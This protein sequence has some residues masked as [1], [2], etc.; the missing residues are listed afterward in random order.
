MPSLYKTIFD[1]FTLCLQMTFKVVLSYCWNKGQK[2]WNI[3]YKTYVHFSFCSNSVILENKTL[4]ASFF[5]ITS[6]SSKP[7]FCVRHVNRFFNSKFIYWYFLLMFPLC[8][9]L[10]RKT[11]PCLFSYS[12]GN[13]Y[14][15][16]QH[17]LT[18]CENQW[19]YVVYW[20]SSVWLLRDENHPLA[21]SHSDIELAPSK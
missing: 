14:P 15:L 10:I 21:I 7:G 20:W 17:L 16:Q 1:H 8:V 5:I 3:F 12:C 4:S 2:W 13:A 9:A 19:Y 6:I 11:I 18:I